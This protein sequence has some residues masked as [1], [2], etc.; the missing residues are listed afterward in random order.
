MFSG[1]KMRFKDKLLAIFLQPLK[2]E[3]CYCADGNVYKKGVKKAKTKI[4]CMCALT[5]A[6]S[7]VFSALL[8]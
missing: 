7:E 1:L 8:T 5:S 3:G 6:S 4:P 2:N